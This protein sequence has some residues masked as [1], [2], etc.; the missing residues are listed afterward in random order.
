MEV[1]PG[2]YV[3]IRHDRRWGPDINGL[4]R[5]VPKYRLDHQVLEMFHVQGGR[6]MCD[7]YSVVEEG[8]VIIVP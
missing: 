4:E 7:S 1:R 6:Y 2:T 3:P 8:Q 5:Y